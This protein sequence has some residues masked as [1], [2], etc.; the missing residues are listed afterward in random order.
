MSGKN[1]IQQ[2]NNA[3]KM[4]PKVERTLPEINLCPNCNGAGGID[5]KMSYGHGDCGYENLRIRCTK[6]SLSFGNGY[7]YSEPTFEAKVKVIKEWNEF[8]EKIK[9]SL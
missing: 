8:T 1:Y 4:Q 2:F 6:C 5:W 9:P 3:K 7:N